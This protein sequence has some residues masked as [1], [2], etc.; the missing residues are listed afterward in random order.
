MHLSAPATSPESTVHAPLLLG[1]AGRVLPPAARS[2]AAARVHAPAAKA[3]VV[4]T[5]AFTFSR[6]TLYAAA[7]ATPSTS[8]HRALV[9]PQAVHRRPQVFSL[10]PGPPSIHLHS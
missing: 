6:P 2:H 8:K 9:D 7:V 5:R 4:K 10:P 3:R 1:A